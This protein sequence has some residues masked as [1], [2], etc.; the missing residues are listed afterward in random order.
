MI[1]VG[2]ERLY[3]LYIGKKNKKEGII[4]AGWTF[5]ALL[6]VHV[7]IILF[8]LLEYLITNKRINWAISIFAFAI[9]LFSFILRNA[10]IRAL[11]Q[12]HSVHIEIRNKHSLIKEGIYSRMRHPYYAGVL[13][14][15]LSIPLIFNC[16]FTLLGVIIFYYPFLFY[17][18]FKEEESM[19]KKFGNEYIDYKAHTGFLLPRMF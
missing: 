1:C 6:I 7:F 5:K 19:A 8:T 11:G 14:E 4:Q 18:I 13:L 12:Y 10:A 17:R 16:Y 3:E 15:L 9:F 2:L